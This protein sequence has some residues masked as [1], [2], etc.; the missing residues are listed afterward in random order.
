MTYVAFYYSIVSSAVDKLRYEGN[1]MRVV[2]G[3]NHINQVWF[4]GGKPP[5]LALCAQPA[6][7]EGTRGD[8]QTILV[9]DNNFK[10]FVINLSVSSMYV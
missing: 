2:V 6:G 1:A 3:S 7:C 5:L 10:I 8:V 4:G 9:T